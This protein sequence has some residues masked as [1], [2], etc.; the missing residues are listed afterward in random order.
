MGLKTIATCVAAISLSIA[1]VV[2]VADSHGMAMKY[3]VG[4]MD[5][6][7]WVPFGEGGPPMAMLWGDMQTGPH[8]FLLKV[9]VGFINEPHTHDADY[10][11]IVLEGSGKHWVEGETMEEVE[12]VTEG[13]HWFQPAGQVHT[14]ANAGDTEAL[15]LVI[16]DGPFS[17]NP[18][19]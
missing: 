7:E 14:D 19:N 12:V 8:A 10:R 1:P 16:V 13:G 2:A 3:S 18:A 6:L 4:N 5:D 15:V 9:P 11:L 17:Y